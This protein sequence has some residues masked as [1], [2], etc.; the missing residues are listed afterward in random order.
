MAKTDIKSMN[1][2]EIVAFLAD[3]GEPRFRAGQLFKWLQSGAEDFDLMTNIPK[4]L[5]EKLKDSCYI[6]NVT[7]E[8]K[9]KSKS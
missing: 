1:E 2:A 5:R 8:R 9:L 3:L 6:A 4:G 7:I